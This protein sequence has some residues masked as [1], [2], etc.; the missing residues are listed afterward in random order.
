M[1]PKHAVGANNRCFYFSE[2]I[3]N[4]AFSELYCKKINGSLADIKDI[5]SL[6]FMKRYK[7][8]FDYWVGVHRNDQNSIWMNYDNTKY[9]LSVPIRDVEDYVYLNN[10]ELSSARI[11]ANRRWICEV[12]F[13]NFIEPPP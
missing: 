2:D 7:C 9:N 4:R 5:D 10:N 3:S 8:K 13:N 1:C 6:I 12:P 11:Y